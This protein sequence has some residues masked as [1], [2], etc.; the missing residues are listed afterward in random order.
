MQS[1]GASTGQT[2]SRAIIRDLYD[3]E[4]A[5][6]MIGLVTSVVVLMPMM[7]PLLGGILDTLFGWTSIFIFIALFS[8]AVFL[9]AALA[10]P[11]T[12]RFSTDP[13]GNGQLIPDLKAL[14]QSPRLL[15]LCVVR[16]ARLGAVLQLPRRRAARHRQMLGRTSAEYG[17]WFF[18]PS[19]GFMAGNF[20]VSRLSRRASASTR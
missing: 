16:R 17:L 5:A 7:A 10:L 13:G 20:V 1:L 9:W 18:L 8:G 12:R 6:S 14:A 19:F 2:I 3:R 15:R 11:E 4:R